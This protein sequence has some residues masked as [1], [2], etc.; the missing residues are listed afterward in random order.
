MEEKL[1]EGPC[2]GC[3]CKNYLLS[4]SGPDICPACAC[5]PP[6]TRVQQLRDEINH[7]NKI[8][9]VLKKELEKKVGGKR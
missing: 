2:K 6:G 8:I 4:T 3:G 7:L 5:Y 9:I 1:Y